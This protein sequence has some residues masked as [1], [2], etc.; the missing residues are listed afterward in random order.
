MI[1]FARARRMMVDNQI[2]TGDV[3]D[4]HVLEAF[5][6]V[7]REAFLPDTQR[8]LAYRDRAVEVEGRRGG[9]KRFL[10]DP[11]VL[12]KL[13][14]L[15][16]L[17]GARNA[18][19]VGCATGYSAALVAELVGEVVAL[20]SDAALVEVARK[21]LAASQNVTVVAGDLTQGWAGGAPYDVVFLDGSVEFVPEALQT[22]VR[23][24][25]RLVAV[26]G[27]GMAGKAMLYRR[28]DGDFSG[29]PAFDAP[30]PALPGFQKPPSFVF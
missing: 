17:E 21:A 4:Q 8:T 12:A 23:D 11:M 13:L 26:V 18:L 20:E 28:V 9:G 22:Q 15:A 19:V 3:T 29:F 27:T 6:A 1:D 14:Q 5:L 7:P 25:G 24:G 16:D 2:R 10:L 30:A